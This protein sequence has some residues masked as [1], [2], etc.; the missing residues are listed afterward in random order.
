M[1]SC[2]ADDTTKFEE[3]AG[4]KVRNALL[5]ITN[6]TDDDEAKAVRGSNAGV[7]SSQVLLMDIDADGRDDPQACTSCVME[8]Y[9]NLRLSER[10]RRPNSSYMEQVQRDIT[11][12]MRSI[13][14]DWLVEVGVEYRLVPETLHL[15]VSYLDRYL[16]V[17]PV[18]RSKLQL[19]GITATLIASKYEEIYAPQLDE[20]CYITDH[21][22]TKE[23]LLICEKDML[24]VLNF[25]LTVPTVRTFI[26]RFL[27]AAQA[28]HKTEFLAMYL[29]ELSLMD[30]GM[31]H[32]LPSHVGAACVFLALLTL[33]KPTTSPTLLHHLG[34]TPSELQQCVRSLHRCFHAARKAPASAIRDK[35]AMHTYMCVSTIAP[36]HPTLPD[37]IFM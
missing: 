32:F 33:G 2:G 22:Y 9:K 37:N 23:E 36:S 27:R 21:A 6:G 26:K 30:Y 17:R 24:H 18:L 31:L 35:Y 28:D 16:S 12:P 8:I 5:D 14:V 4:K 34:Y 3:A 13:L 1:K 29:G 25:E 7:T 10:R 19:V 20:F 11:A 15:A